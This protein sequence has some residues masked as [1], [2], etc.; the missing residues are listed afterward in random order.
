MNIEE[1]KY[2]IDKL[3][4]FIPDCNL[5]CYNCEF[6]VMRSYGNWNYDTCPVGLTIDLLYTKFFHEKE[7]E[8]LH[9]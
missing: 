5:D 8:R 3:N 4:N 7:W 2:I 6:G 1:A 9:G